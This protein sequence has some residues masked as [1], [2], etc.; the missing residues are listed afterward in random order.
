MTSHIELA[1]ILIRDLGFYNAEAAARNI[2]LAG[3]SVMNDDYQRAA[4][5]LK[6]RTCQRCG[7]YCADGVCVWCVVDC[8]QQE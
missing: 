6:A 8:A 1:K 3:H 4:D 7:N 5:W 2:A